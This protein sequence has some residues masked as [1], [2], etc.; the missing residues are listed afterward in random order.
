MKKGWTEPSRTN[1]NKSMGDVL[2]EN[3]YQEALRKRAEAANEA[4][5]KEAA[6][7]ETLPTESEGH[8]K[9]NSDVILDSS[10]SAA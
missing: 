8:N 10:Q 5:L 2:N 1:I 4:R 7:Q 3:R 6:V 9:N